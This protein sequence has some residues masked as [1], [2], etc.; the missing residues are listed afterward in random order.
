MHVSRLPTC[1]ATA[2]DAPETAVEVES[3]GMLLVAASQLT[4]N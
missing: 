1:S 4:A 2:A 3:T